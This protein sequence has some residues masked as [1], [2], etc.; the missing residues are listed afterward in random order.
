M[1]DE[2]S[3]VN[4]TEARIATVQVEFLLRIAWMTI[5]LIFDILRSGG[6]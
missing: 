3:V 1:L 2:A 6:L 5:T 4:Y